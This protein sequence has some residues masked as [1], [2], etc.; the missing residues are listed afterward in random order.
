MPQV[1][2]NTPYLVRTII[3]YQYKI[4]LLANV[5]KTVAVIKEHSVYF[6]SCIV[7]AKNVSVNRHSSPGLTCYHFSSVAE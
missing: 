1:Y 4:A 3:E 7:Y 6:L 5:T 2:S